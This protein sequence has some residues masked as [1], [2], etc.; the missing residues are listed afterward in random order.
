H[1]GN[2]VVFGLVFAGAVIYLP[3]LS[4]YADRV[5]TSTGLGIAYGVLLWIGAAAI[6]MPIWLTAVGFPNAPPLPNL[7]PLSLVGHVAFGAV[8]G[9]LFPVLGNR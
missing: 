6:V 1:L 3:A 7:N 2:S 9:A 4:D 8:L 5:T